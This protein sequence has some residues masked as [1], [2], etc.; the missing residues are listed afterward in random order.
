MFR[1]EPSRYM[2]KARYLIAMRRV[3]GFNIAGTEES[4]TDKSMAFLLA[5]LSM[6]IIAAYF[7]LSEVLSDI[8]LWHRG[9]FDWRIFCSFEF[10]PSNVSKLYGWCMILSER[11]WSGISVNGWN[12]RRAGLNLSKKKD[13]KVKV[14]IEDV[15]TLFLDIRRTCHSFEVPRASC[16]SS[17]LHHTIGHAVNL[18][19]QQS[20][21]MIGSN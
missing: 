9:K 7:L 11:P 3:F 1:C 4:G 5:I 14:V 2:S 10:D 6:L 15:R 8:Y 17:V 18:S 21:T 20:N 13:K 19:M 12:S 16:L